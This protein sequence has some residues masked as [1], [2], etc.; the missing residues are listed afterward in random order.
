MDELL[1][2]D[3]RSRNTDGS[4]RSAQPRTDAERLA[5]EQAALREVAKLVADRSD[6]SEVF[7][8]ATIGLGRS[9]RAAKAGLWRFE[10]TGEITTVAG[11]AEPG[12][13]VTWP[14]GSRRKG[15]RHW[16]AGA[17]G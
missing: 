15:P 2:G 6:L 4:R 12:K 17:T 14:V 8:A 1:V 13:L 16:S 10:S 11:A 7:D 9:I 5:A 3:E